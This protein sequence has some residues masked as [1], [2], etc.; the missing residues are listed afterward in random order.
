MERKVIP[1]LVLAGLIISG[2]E[3]K[4]DAVGRA[5]EVYIFTDHKESIEFDISLSLE[6][7]I[8]TPQ[9]GVEFFLKY[10]EGDE[11]TDHLRRHCILLAGYE[12]DTAIRFMKNLYPPLTCNDSFNLYTFRDVW[13][14][15]QTVMV[16]VAEDS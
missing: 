9:P 3:Y 2:C 14:E 8:F 1:C 4:P 16:F 11:A 6:R 15:G 12:S 5:R 13:A 10:K 7:Q